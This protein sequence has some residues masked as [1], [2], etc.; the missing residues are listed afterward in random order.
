LTIAVARQ[1]G[2][3]DV[4]DRFHARCQSYNLPAL[5]KDCDLAAGNKVAKAPDSSGPRMPGLGGFR[6]PGLPF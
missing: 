4:A 3:D 5:K 2:R 1:A 6:P